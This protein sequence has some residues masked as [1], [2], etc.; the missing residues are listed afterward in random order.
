MYW[1]QKAEEGPRN[2]LQLT[3]HFSNHEDKSNK[4]G[5]DELYLCLAC[6]IV[7]DF[8]MTFT[9][10]FIFHR[11]GTCVHHKGGPTTGTLACLERE[12]GEGDEREEGEGERRGKQERR[13]RGREV[14]EREREREVRES[15]SGS[16]YH[17]WGEPEWTLLP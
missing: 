16:Y 1:K 6:G 17:N 15:L 12:G 4:T 5:D 8:L 3:D 14:R 2:N 9:A 7:C 10:D 11:G 13:Q